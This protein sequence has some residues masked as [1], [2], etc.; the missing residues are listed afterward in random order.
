MTK[1]DFF[2]LQSDVENARL[3]FCCKLIDKAVRQG[4]R[5][6]IYT[7]DANSSAEVDEQ[8]WRFR[9]ESYIPHRIIDSGE[10]QPQIHVPPPVTI[11][12]KQDDDSHHDVLVCLAN[13]IPEYFARFNRYIQV[14][15]QDKKRLETSRL[16]FAFFRDRGYPIDVKKLKH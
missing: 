16:H 3:T 6:F 4:N 13:S 5:V 11:S 9:P 8:L 2:I 15:N 12:H 7:D 10:I 14:V 1:I